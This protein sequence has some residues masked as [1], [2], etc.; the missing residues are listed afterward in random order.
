MTVTKYPP[1]AYS[2]ASGDVLPGDASCVHGGA[3]RVPCGGAMRSVA[4]HGGRE[5]PLDLIEEHLTYEVLSPQY[6]QG[7][8]GGRLLKNWMF[9]ESWKGVKEGEP[10]FVLKIQAF[11]KGGYEGTIRQLDLEKIGRAIEG[12]GIRGKR[13]AP[14]IVSVENQYK[15]GRQVEAENAAPGKKHDG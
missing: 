9:P 14:D 2:G 15:S 7:S 11:S 4:P 3:I 8:H 6:R 5:A 1:T 10:N 12:G 13:E